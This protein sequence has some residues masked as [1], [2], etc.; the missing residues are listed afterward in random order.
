M[1]TFVGWQT[2]SLIQAFFLVLASFPEVQEKART[3]LDA[4]VGPHR[5]PD[6]NDR[7]ALPY[8]C[9]VIKEC[10]RW[11]AIAPLGIPHRLVQDDE[12]RGYLI[13]KGTL[14][15]PNTWYVASLGPASSC[16]RVYRLLDLRAFSR[17]EKRYPDPEA[18]VPERFLKNGKLNA[19]T[20]GP[21]EFAFGYG[22]RCVS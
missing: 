3:E 6:F 7:D 4:V 18:F 15:I 11:H 20:T 2:F 17:D 19:D 9:A 21:S 1:L 14:V 13:P 8:V 22:R 16:Q 5:L 10:M 12:Y